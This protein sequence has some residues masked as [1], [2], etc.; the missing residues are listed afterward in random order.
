MWLQVQR[1]QRQRDAHERPT[2]STSIQ[3]E[4]Q[5]RSGNYRHQHFLQQRI[6]QMGL[7]VVL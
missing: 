2:A 6:Q 1:S 4:S 3:E 7:E 5:P